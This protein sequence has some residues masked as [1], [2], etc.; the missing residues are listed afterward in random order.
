[1]AQ[2]PGTPPPAPPSASTGPEHPIA[3]R[4]K[5]AIK[6]HPVLRE[7]KKLHVKVVNGAVRLEGSVFTRDTMR[8]LLD[9]MARFPGGNEVT[10]LVETDV[11]PPEPRPLVGQV[12]PVSPGAGGVKRSYSVSHLPPKP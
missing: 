10:V 11:A 12:P 2:A 5:S 3:A 6:A 7:E 1:M 8:Q 9:L 4:L